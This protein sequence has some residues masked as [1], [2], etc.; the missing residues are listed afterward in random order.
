MMPFYSTGTETGFDS[1]MVDHSGGE[2]L[3]KLQRFLDPKKTD[4]QIEAEF[5]VGEGTSR[6]L[7]QMREGFRRD[8]EKNAGYAKCL[9][10]ARTESGTR[11]S[12]RSPIIWASRRWAA[13]N[14]P[15]CLPARMVRD[16][17]VPGPVS[18]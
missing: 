18:E 17:M 5:S 10:M 15:L 4:A 1:L 7:L 2:L 3:A 8:F 11:R 9:A 13:P 14:D 16:P 12:V 6:K